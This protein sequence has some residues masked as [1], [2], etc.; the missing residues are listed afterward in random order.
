MNHSDIFDMK[1]HLAHAP[2]IVL[3]EIKDLENKSIDIQFQ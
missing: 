2:L 1:P 3:K